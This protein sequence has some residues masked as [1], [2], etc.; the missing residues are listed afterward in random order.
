MQLYLEG[1][2]FRAIGRFLGVSHVAVYYW[3]R[4]FGKAVESVRNAAT[5]AKVV[6][7]DELHSYVGHKKTTAGSYP[8]GTSGR[9]L[10]DMGNGSSVALWVVPRDAETG[11]RP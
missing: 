11:R 2:G 1:M 5:E 9:L 6:E 8:Q 3:V 7:M 10:I 4:S